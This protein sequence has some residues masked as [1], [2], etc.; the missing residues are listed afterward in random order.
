MERAQPGLALAVRSACFAELRPDALYGIL[1]LRSEVFV[2]EQGCVY[3]DADGRD[4]D[5]S[6][7]H[8]WIEDPA[9][10]AGV[11]ACARLVRERDGGSRVGRVVTRASHRRRG[12]AGSVVDA[13]L[14][15]APRPVTVHAQAH[16]EGWYARRFGF[17]REGDEF[18]EDGIPHVPMVLAP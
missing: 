15:V 10:G 7:V 18:L 16:L 3:L 9:T 13:A 4:C 6:T 2:V 12:L 1:R 17:V 14:R 11:V 8:W 5:P